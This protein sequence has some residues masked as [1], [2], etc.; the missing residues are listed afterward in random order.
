MNT[1]DF[2]HLAFFNFLSYFSRLGLI[3]GLNRRQRHQNDPFE[4]QAS[5]AVLEAENLCVNGTPTCSN[6]LIHSG[7]A[8]SPGQGTVA[9]GQLEKSSGRS[10]GVEQRLPKLR[11]RVRVPPRL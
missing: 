10:L 2:N 11:T 5:F 7:R 6:R 1:G 8:D 4:L 3:S 9:G